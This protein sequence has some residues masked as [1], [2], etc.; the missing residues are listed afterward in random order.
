MGEINIPKS[1][2]WQ[3][4]PNFC[5]QTM[6]SNWVCIKIVNRNTATFARRARILSNGNQNWLHRARIWEQDQE[7]YIQA[8]LNNISLQDL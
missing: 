8:A 1:E 6:V 4:N 3:K 7:R 5:T 2:N